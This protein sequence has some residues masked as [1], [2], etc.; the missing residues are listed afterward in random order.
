M[1]GRDGSPAAESGAHTAVART[2]NVVAVTESL[3][4]RAREIAE[5][6]L[7]PAAL[8][9]DGTGEIPDTHWRSLAEAGLYGIAVPAD[10][11]GPDLGFGDLIEILELMAAGCLAT[12][13][14]WVQHHGMLAALSATTNTALRDEL[15]PDVAAGRTRGGVAFAGA[16]PV[17]PRMR[18]DRIDGGWR[19]VGH[20][21]FVSGWG[22]I[23]VIQ[24]S[25]GD[26]A[27]GDIV[28]GVLAAEMQPGITSVQAQSLF[29]ADATKT[30]SIDVDGLVIPD[31]RVVSRVTRADFMANQ[32]F[33]S[34]LNGTLPIGVVRRCIDLLDDGGR[35]DAAER[36]RADATTV[37]ARLDAGLADSAALLEARAEAAELAVR[38]AAAVVANSGGPALL[39]TSPA[40]LVARDATFTLVAASRPELKQSLVRRFS[41]P[42]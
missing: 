3:V 2:A 29:G 22:V 28:S 27:S 9:V 24:F 34:R 13:F 14:T 12:A 4:D 17:P 35:P 1:I 33:G 41:T 42:S 31:D 16:V 32:N 7:F 37:R 5:S 40:Q 36:L 11:G 15:L 30:V 19:L 25:A 20:A 39:R 38:A 21:P 18:A 23:D 10:L 26:N 6:V 8:D